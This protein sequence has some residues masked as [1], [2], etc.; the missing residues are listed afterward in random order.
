MNI[1][2]S[3]FMKNKIFSH[4]KQMEK[5]H[6]WELL[7]NKEKVLNGTILSNLIQKKLYEKLSKI[8]DLIE[9][10]NLDVSPAKLKIILV[11]HKLDSKLY[12]ENKIKKCR[13]IGMASELKIFPETIKKEEL[14]E[15]IEK[16]NS[17]KDV[18]GIIIQLPL[19]DNLV[20]N[21]TEILSKVNLDKDVDGLNPLNQGK[22]L[23]MNFCE[24]LLPPTAMGV[25]ELL[26]LAI[27]F[28][29]DIDRYIKDY[30]D[31]NIFYDKPLDLSGMDVTVLG[32]GLTAGMPVS[33]LMQKCNGT[34]TTCHS[35][36]L[37]IQNKCENADILI[38]A[39]G[40]PNLVNKY[41]VK[42]DS[43]L[44]DVG[45]NVE[46]TDNEK[47]I[48]KGDVD[49]DDVVEKVKYITPVPGGVGKMTVIMLLK[50]VLKAWS[51]INKINLNKI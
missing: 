6:K 48:I 46:K 20:P 41:Y 34:V 35:K 18:H 31:E 33:I 14:L 23:Q 25:M 13:A 24:C 43:I 30:L 8:N 22:I 16:S 26:R 37:N 28:N 29:N 51:I 9:S 49:F 7:K 5:L 40:K 11:G 19:P 45:I 32:R 42:P 21:R 4:L 27:D 36:T 3:Y 38:S 1:L 47:K 2:I 15:E 12:V 50:N 10:N 39:V 17:D 44:I